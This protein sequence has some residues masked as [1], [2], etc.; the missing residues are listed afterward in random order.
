[1]QHCGLHAVNAL[2]GRRAARPVDAAEM[3]AVNR[4]LHRRER[5]IHRE[6]D[7]LRPDP[8]GNYPVEVLIQVLAR[9]GLHAEYVHRPRR[10]RRRGTVGYLLATGAHYVALVR[11]DDGWVVWDNGAETPHRAANAQAAA[12]TWLAA[13]GGRHRVA[14]VLRVWRHAPLG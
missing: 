14:A 2:L 4:E 1:M 12:G 13:A 7:D 6:G 11:D 10:A 3:D 8:T 5:E 9:R